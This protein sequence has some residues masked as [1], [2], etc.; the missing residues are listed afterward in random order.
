L[1]IEVLR[2][3]R[4]KFRQVR[5]RRRGYRF[6]F[7]VF[8]SCQAVEVVFTVVKDVRVDRDGSFPSYENRI[9]VQFEVGQRVFAVWWSSWVGVRDPSR[10]IERDRNAGFIHDVPLEKIR[11]RR[12]SNEERVSEFESVEIL[13]GSECEP[14][15][16]ACTSG[17][18]GFVE[19]A[20]S[21]S[22][23]S[24]TKARRRS[25]GLGGDSRGIVEAP[26]QEAVV[27]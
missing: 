1:S 17:G 4:G 27:L 11:A 8:R 23:V 16:V 9:V 6:V 7:N 25:I 24:R 3:E 21:G 10:E 2:R 26:D 14:R 20:E 15:V 5:G 22:D 19:R 13:W 18:K 12:R